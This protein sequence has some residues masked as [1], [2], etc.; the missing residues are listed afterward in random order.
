MATLGF[1]ELTGDEIRDIL[2]ENGGMV[3]DELETF[4]TLEAGINMWSKYKPVIS[5]VLFYSKEEWINRAY[6]GQSGT[7]GLYIP[8]DNNL[9][10]F[11]SMV[12]NGSDKWIYEP[13][14]GGENAPYR[15][16]DFRGYCSDASNPVGGVMT[17]GYR[18]DNGMVEFNIEV[19][20]GSDSETNVSLSDLTVNGLPLSSYYLGIYAYN[21]DN[22]Y[23]VKTG[24]SSIGDAN[25]LSVSVQF[26]STGTFHYVPILS[27]RIQNGEG[28]DATL[29]GLNYNPMTVTI[30][31]Y[32][33]SYAATVYAIWSK[34][35]S[36]LII[37]F[38]EFHNMGNI[39]VEFNNLTAY[40]V[41][42]AIGSSGGDEG[43]P[44]REIVIPGSWSVPAKERVV[45]QVD[46]TINLSK[47]ET[48]EYWIG[49][50]AN[51]IDSV[52]SWMQIQ[53]PIDEAMIARM[54]S[55]R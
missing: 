55:R 5:S 47:D 22:K 52:K 17:N 11:R 28:V 34:D 32:K 40:L 26:D 33:G 24:E 54:F 46:L 25:G 3:D 49:A 31:D 45:A 15:L 2:T 51:L 44:V 21:D 13:P 48:K 37:E 7:C 35:Y 1:D 9:S 10:V 14:Y 16:R 38:V 20:H 12:K 53:D 36:S 29:V 23:Y 8:F 41:K 39:S 30:V 6:K 50:T 42:T 18:D 4:F 43:E 27:S 19:V